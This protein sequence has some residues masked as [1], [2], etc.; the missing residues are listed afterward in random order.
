ME[1]NMKTYDDKDISL[2]NKKLFIKF[3]WVIEERQ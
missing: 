1:K 2:I 3:E